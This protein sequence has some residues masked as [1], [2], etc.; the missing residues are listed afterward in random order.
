MTVGIGQRYDIIVEALPKPSDGNYW[1]RTWRS[2]CFPQDFPNGT[3]N[4]EENGIVS[5]TKTPATPKTKGYQP[6]LTCEDEP[7]ASLVPVVQRIVTKPPANDKIGGVGENF[8]V[9]GSFGPPDG[10]F[11]FP[12]AHFSMGG[13]NFNPLRIDY[14][15]PT[16]LNLNNSGGWDPR[17]IMY[18]ENYTDVDWVGTEYQKTSS[19]ASAERTSHLDH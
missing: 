3:T 17:Q 10:T 8:T 9:L 16:F 7:Y 13:Q 12:L 11:F 4:Y 18:P 5:Y 2:D 6:D 15:N 19:L 1:I 14:G